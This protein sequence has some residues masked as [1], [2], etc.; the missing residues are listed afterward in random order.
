MKDEP[1]EGPVHRA[2]ESEEGTWETEEVSHQGRDNG[3][4]F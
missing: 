4:S 2:R 3:F 1:V